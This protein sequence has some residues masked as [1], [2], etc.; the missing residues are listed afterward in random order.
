MSNRN[1]VAGAFGSTGTDILTLVREDRRAART[2]RQRHSQPRR[3]R[4]T[5]PT[6]R[7]EF[8]ALFAGHVTRAANKRNW[9]VATRTLVVA[10][11]KALTDEDGNGQVPEG[12]DGFPARLVQQKF[13]MSI[14]LSKPKGVE[15]PGRTQDWFNKAFDDA[16]A[17]RMSL[18]NQRTS[19]DQAQQST[20][21]K[22]PVT[23]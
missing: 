7:E 15:F 4:S 16:Y 10:Y 13:A 8:T 23:V 11:I 14:L 12:L 6:T 18:R 1:S 3:Q 21:D 19:A 2:D 22:E 17:Y 5:Q 20:P 9:S